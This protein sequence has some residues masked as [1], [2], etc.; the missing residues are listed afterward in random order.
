MLS[1]SLTLV[2]VIL[3]ALDLPSLTSS[4]RLVF[5]H[6][7]LGCAAVTR[8]VKERSAVMVLGA[9]NFMVRVGTREG[10]DE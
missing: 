2:L 7:E 6:P 5:A 10:K 9:R 8:V 3:T 1:V 4:G